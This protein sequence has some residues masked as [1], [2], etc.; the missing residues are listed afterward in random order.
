MEEES[1]KRK[2]RLRAMRMEASQS[3]SSSPAGTHGMV[4]HLANPLIETAAIALPHQDSHVAPPPRFDYYTDPMAAYSGNRVRSNVDAQSQLE[5]PGYTTPAPIYSPSLSGPR[6]Y[7][8]SSSLTH[9]LQPSIPPNSGMYQPVP[10]QGFTHHP[11]PRSPGSPYQMHRGMSSQ[12]WNAFGQATDHFRSPNHMGRGNPYPFRGSGR[13]GPQSFDHSPH[14]GR[15]GGRGLGYRGRGS[16][17]GGRLGQ[18][19]FFHESM[20]QDPWK[21]LTPVLWKG[22]DFPMMGSDAPESSSS[23]MPKSI[24]TKKPKVTESPQKFG[25]GANLAEFLA[26]AFNESSNEPTNP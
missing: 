18:E 23:W 1:E 10:P 22:V 16:S 13:S 25:S 6:I 21:D 19:R 7:R 20:L 9:Q 14:P 26:A 8:P 2:E 24:Q 17:P 11:I 12:S 3:Q 15:S 4:D 5:T